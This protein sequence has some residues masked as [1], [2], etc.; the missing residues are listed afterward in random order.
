MNGMPGPK[1]SVCKSQAQFCPAFYLQQLQG[2]KYPLTHTI[3]C[4]FIVLTYYLTFE[5]FDNSC[6]LV[7]MRFVITSLFC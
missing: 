5:V 7:F 2:C 3:K 4:S 1:G 6:V